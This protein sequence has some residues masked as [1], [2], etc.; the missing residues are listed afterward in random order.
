MDSRRTAA[1]FVLM[2]AQSTL[3]AVAEESASS[4]SSSSSE[5]EGGA[6]SSSSPPLLDDG[7]FAR[8]KLKGFFMECVILF[9]ILGFVRFAV[10]VRWAQRNA[11]IWRKKEK[12]ITGW[13]DFREAPKYDMVLPPESTIFDRYFFDPKTGASTGKSFSAVRF[14]LILR[15]RAIL[16]MMWKVNQDHPEMSRLHSSGLLDTESF[17][18]VDSAMAMM[19][20]EI[21]DLED[22]AKKVGY[23]PTEEAPKNPNVWQ[24]GRVL[25]DVKKRMEAE[26]Q[27]R[28]AQHEEAERK[29]HEGEKAARQAAAKNNNG[30]NGAQSRVK[31][32]TK[33]EK[34]DRIAKELMADEDNEKKK[35]NARR[36]KG[37][38]GKKT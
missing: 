27:Q 16:P 22:T 21:K 25:I 12:K 5:E 38:K 30:G 24:F 31:V 37:K 9:G 35:M 33:E 3:G 23:I 29:R 7:G 19:K 2:L 32:E 18:A 11:W 13:D 17:D 4:S 20:A 8:S 34:A 10:Y 1:A 6:S 36:K 28:I 15:A 26:K 14:G